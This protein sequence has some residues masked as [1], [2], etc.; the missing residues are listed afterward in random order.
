MKKMS[1]GYIVKHYDDVN[2]N[3]SFYIDAT[4]FVTPVNGKIDLARPIIIKGVFH[5][6]EKG[7]I[8]RTFI[9][10]RL[11]AYKGQ[12]LISYDDGNNDSSVEEFAPDSFY[13]SLNFPKG[14]DLSFTF[15]ADLGPEPIAADL[16]IPVGDMPG[17]PFQYEP[18]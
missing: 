1:N 18:E 16:Y 8:T 11:S 9:I 14:M 7:M 6:S 5:D 3:N 10:Q 12:T 2:D 4:D 13:I 17:L 15:K